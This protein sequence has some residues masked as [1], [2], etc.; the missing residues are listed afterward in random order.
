MNKLLVVL[1][2]LAAPVMGAE[3][4]YEK[5]VKTTTN[6]VVTIEVRG[7]GAQMTLI[8]LL[9][10][11]TGQYGPVGVSGSGSIITGDGVILTCDHLFQRQMDDRTITVK[12]ANGKKYRAILLDEDKAKDLAILKIFPLHS[13]SSFKLGNALHRGQRVLSFGSPLG[14]ENTVS[15]GYV[16]N[17]SAKDENRTRTLH[18]ASINPGNSG[19]PLVDEMGNLVGVNIETMTS[20]EAMHLAV[21]LK[22]IHSFLGE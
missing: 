14:Y 4:G 22:D 7:M 18:S 13:L 6:K 8:D 20:T 5:L 10:G 11:T 2:L 19:G 15:F 12:D 16:E 9:S 1:M 17:L 21:T 3:T